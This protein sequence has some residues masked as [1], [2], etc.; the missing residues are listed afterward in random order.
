MIGINEVQLGESPI[1]TKPIQ[2]STNQN[3]WILVFDDYIFETLIINTKAE[4]SI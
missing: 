3:Q 2:Q 4:A 1:I